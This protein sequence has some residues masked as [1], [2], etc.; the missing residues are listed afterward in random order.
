MEERIKRVMG[1]I[2]GLDPDDI[3]EST[4]MDAVESWDSA[5]HI[6]L[7]IGLEQEFQLHLDVA[8]MESMVSYADIL[9]VMSHKA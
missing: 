7:C 6:S 2:L 4:S 1:D 5:N 8:D 3:D 9:E